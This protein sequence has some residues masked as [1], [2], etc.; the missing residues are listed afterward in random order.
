M[1]LDF[2]SQMLRCRCML[3]PKSALSRLRTHASP[4]NDW[5]GIWKLNPVKSH[6]YGPTLQISRSSDVVLGQWIRR[7]T[8]NRAHAQLPQRQRRQS[9][10]VQLIFVADGPAYT[11]LVSFRAA[12][13]KA[14][15]S[16]HAKVHFA[17]NQRP[18]SWSKPALEQ[19]G[20]AGH[21]PRNRR[22]IPF[23][24]HGVLR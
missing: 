6:I 23:R 7:H 2:K 4:T 10:D 22:S 18:T 20:L 8:R 1:N 3:Q 11:H 21:I 14:E 19:R 12:E 5:N 17:H 9:Q 13:N 15:P 16:A 24:A